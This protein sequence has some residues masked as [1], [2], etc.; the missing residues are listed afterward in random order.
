MKTSEEADWHTLHADLVE[1]LR[2]K[3]PP[4]V[5]HS[6]YTTGEIQDA[7]D[8]RCL[9]ATLRRFLLAEKLDVEKASQRLANHSLWRRQHIP[10]GTIS[11]VSTVSIGAY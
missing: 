2:H 1:T 10:E 3:V 7:A 4:D 6:L 11:E 5:L 8:E 9:N